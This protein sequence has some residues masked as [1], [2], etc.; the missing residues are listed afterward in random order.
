MNKPTK[1]KVLKAYHKGNLKQSIYEINTLDIYNP[2]YLYWTV[3]HKKTGSIYIV[4]KTC[5]KRLFSV[6]KL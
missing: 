1:D 4:K 3:R 6:V 2:D 5:G